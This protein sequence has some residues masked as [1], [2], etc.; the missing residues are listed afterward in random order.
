VLVALDFRTGAY[1]WHFQEVCHDIWDYDSSSM[2]VA[3]KDGGPVNLTL[4]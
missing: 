4:I 3:G 1:K 2:D